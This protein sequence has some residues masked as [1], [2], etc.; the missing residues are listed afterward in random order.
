[1][2]GFEANPEGLM[3][4]GKK[5]IEYYT[6]YMKQKTAADK[7]TDRIAAGWSGADANGSVTAIRSYD[8][9]YKLL[10]E[11]IQKIGDIL[12]RHGARLANSRDA[13][14]TAAEKL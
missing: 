10:G 8:E 12:Y 7:T 2:N 1:M 14:V 6:D 11:T 13:I 5:V 4:K 3:D 9:T